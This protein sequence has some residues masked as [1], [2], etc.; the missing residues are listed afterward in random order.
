MGTASLECQLNLCQLSL[1]R[2]LEGLQRL[3]YRRLLVRSEELIAEGRV[4]R[5]TLGLFQWQG[6]G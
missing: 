2:G 5:L 4:E 1:Q 6:L 3:S